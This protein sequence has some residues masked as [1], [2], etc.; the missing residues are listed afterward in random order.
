MSDR[1][2]NNERY[3]AVRTQC[4]IKKIAYDRMWLLKPCS[5]LELSEEISQLTLLTAAINMMV[6]YD[7]SLILNSELQQNGFQEVSLCDGTI[8]L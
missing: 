4:G 3:E 8:M 6:K 5:S 1:I 7:A 2:K